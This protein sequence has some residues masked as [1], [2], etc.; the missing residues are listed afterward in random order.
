MDVSHHNGVVDFEKWAAHRNVEFVFI[1]MTEGI[2]IIDASA[3]RHYNNAKKAGLSVGFYHYFRPQRSGKKHFA[4]MKKQPDIYDYD[5]ISA[6]DVETKYCDWKQP[7]ARKNMDEF[8]VS[9]YNCYGYYPV[10]YSFI[11]VSD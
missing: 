4:F 5:L 10:L 2:H 6:L 9:F 3:P 7:D 11:L 1:K 8:I